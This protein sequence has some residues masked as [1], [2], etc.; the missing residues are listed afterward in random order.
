[1][2]AKNLNLYIIGEKSSDPET[3]THWSE[4]YLV[5]AE[6]VQQAREV[7]EMRASD[8]TPITQVDITKPQY[9][10]GIR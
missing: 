1:M 7:A 10:T 4:S 8:T 5:V 6:S 3:W 9:L 2:N